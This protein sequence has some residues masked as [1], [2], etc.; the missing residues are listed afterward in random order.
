L[1]LNA[2][3]ETVGGVALISLRGTPRQLASSA[4]SGVGELLLDDF[5]AVQDLGMSERTNKDF[6]AWASSVRVCALVPA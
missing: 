1:L 6:F 2:L 5:D 4:A 3:L